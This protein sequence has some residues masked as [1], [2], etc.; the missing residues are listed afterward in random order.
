MCQ[1]TS[2][3]RSRKCAQSGAHD[4]H[5]RECECIVRHRVN[6][7]SC[8]PRLGLTALARR[9]PGSV[10]APNAPGAPCAG[11][12]TA[13]GH[14]ASARDPA[15]ARPARTGAHPGAAR[16]GR[17]R[18]RRRSGEAG[19]GSRPRTARS[20]DGAPGATASSRSVPTA[21]SRRRGRATQR[22]AP[23]VLPQLVDPLGQILGVG[24]DGQPEQKEAQDENK[25]PEELHVHERTPPSVAIACPKPPPAPAVRRGCP[26]GVAAAPVRT[27]RP[28]AWSGRRR[29]PGGTAGWRRTTRPG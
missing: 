23:D 25:P 5:E 29:A 21:R 12:D 1:F 2:A 16:P 13:H 9:G 10:P 28:P 26:S 4:H 3:H 6:G 8:R 7:T 11:L 14:A 18:S 15:P 27:A 17:D 19:R 22:T 24:G 20:S